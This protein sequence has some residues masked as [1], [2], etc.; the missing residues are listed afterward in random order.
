MEEITGAPANV[1]TFRT[2]PMAFLADMAL[3]PMSRKLH[4][5]IESIQN[6]TSD[7]VLRLFPLLSLTSSSSHFNPTVHQLPFIPRPIVHR[8][9]SIP[10]FTSIVEKASIESQIIVP[11]F[12]F[13]GA[14]KIPQ[15]SSVSP[16]LHHSPPVPK[17][18]AGQGSQHVQS[19]HLPLLGEDGL[20]LAV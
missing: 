18:R 14:L 10:T 20:T 3:I 7:L 15:L 13:R 16:H 1:G 2:T 17:K 6:T 9:E 11:F 12:G 5:R 4:S 19:S 8:L